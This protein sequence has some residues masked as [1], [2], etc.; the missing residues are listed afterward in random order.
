M[1]VFSPRRTKYNLK[2]AARMAE[3]KVLR[4]KIALVTGGSRGLGSSIAVALADAGADIALNYRTRKGEAHDVC[5]V[6]EERGR[7]C[8]TVQADVSSATD[9]L[10]MVAT[11]EQRLGSVDILVNNAGMAKPQSLAEIDEVSWDQ[12]LDTN[13]KS[14]FLATQA[15]LSPMRKNRWG[16]I[17][18]ISSV[19]AQLGGLIG[20]HYAAS[21]AGLIGL[22]HS[23]A[24]LLAKEGITVNAVA[25]A[26]IATDM[27]RDNAN[28]R[29]EIIPVGRF[30]EAREVSDV[31]V[32]LACNG[33]M[34]GQ[35]VN[36]NGGWY[37]T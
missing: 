2:E 6:I 11:I 35:T 34:T 5:T 22:T 21:K 3:Q 18:N 8:L 12:T 1:A 7:R 19:A 23:Y 13:L 4:G 33:Y 9:V 17:I 24:A 29:R 25:P 20:P 28:A 15:V 37:M 16:R 10:D 14:A 27:I 30:G 31:V 32:M 36:V 26:L